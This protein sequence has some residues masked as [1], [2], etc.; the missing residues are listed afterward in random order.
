MVVAVNKLNLRTRDVHKTLRF[1]RLVKL[2]CPDGLTAHSNESAKLLVR[3]VRKERLSFRE[4]LFLLLYEPGSSSA[5][6]VFAFLTWIL[7]IIGT[8]TMN[9]ETVYL[10]TDLTGDEP[11]LVARCLVNGFFTIECIARF[12]CYIPLRNAKYDLFLV[13]T[14][15]SVLPFWGRFLGTQSLRFGRYLKTYERWTTTRVMEGWASMRLV[16]LCRYYEGGA[17]IARTAKRSMKELGV[18]MFMLLVLATTFSAVLYEVEW[19]PVMDE[20]VRLWVDQGVS[21]SF[22]RDPSR[23]EGVQWNCDVCT[24]APTGGECLTCAGYPGSHTKCAGVGWRQKFDSVPSAMWF[25]GVTMTTVGY[26]DQTP[27]TWPGQLL[28]GAIILCGVLF[29]AMPLAIVGNN[30]ADVWSDRHMARLRGLVRQLLIENELEID[31]EGVARAFSSAD[32]DDRGIVDSREFA[33]FV[34]ETLTLRLDAV[35]M[36]T[37][38]RKCD[39]NLSGSLTITEFGALF[40]PGVASAQ[41]LLRASEHQQQAVIADFDQEKGSNDPEKLDRL[42]RASTQNRLSSINARNSASGGGEE[43]ARAIVSVE[44]SIESMQEAVMQRCDEIERRMDQ[45]S[46]HDEALI[47]HITR[48][49]STVDALQEGSFSPLPVRRQDALFDEAVI[50]E[51]SQVP[52]NGKSSPQKSH[53]RMRRVRRIPSRKAQTTANES[54][55]CGNV[56]TSEVITDAAP[57]SV[58]AEATNGVDVPPANN[59]DALTVLAAGGPAQGSNVSEETLNA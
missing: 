10:I 8:V 43:M 49:Q 16:C 5:A 22:L 59:E 18:S 3:R 57:A 4:S 56:V 14:F 25:V 54:A 45:R 51:R 55:Q 15:L 21:I 1:A 53:S 38:W 41:I 9:M 39:L 12:L 19:D 52:P 26:G 42:I 31:A 33:T 7:L 28:C 50:L 11:W 17:I 13:I 34:S 29:L 20:C 58:A 27:E 37:L 6:A 44:A 30:F 47:A 46:A 48:L 2:V 23:S 24:D 32:V 35:D 40:F 36:A